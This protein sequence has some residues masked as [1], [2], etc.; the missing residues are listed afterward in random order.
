MTPKYTA[1]TK[2]KTVF[3]GT[4]TAVALLLSAAPV[5]TVVAA[6]TLTLS[7]WLPPTHPF[8][9]NALKPWADQV[10]EATNGN[11]RIRIL[12]KPLGSPLIH[13]DLA[14]DGIADISYGLQSYTKGTRFEVSNVAQFPFLGESAE[15]VSAAYWQVAEETP[16]IFAEH[17]GTHVLSLFTHGPG[18]IQ[19]RTENKIEK[20][21]DLE[22]LKV[23]VPGGVANDLIA[24]L[25]AEQM[26]VSPSE[27]YET[28]SRGVIDA[29]TM[30][31]ETMV[32]YKFIDAVD[33][34]TQIPGGLY[35]TT[36]FMSMN[37]GRWDSLSEDD[38]K[39]IMSVSGEAFARLQG[40]AWDVADAA[41]WEAIKEADIPVTVADDAF[42]AEINAA[43][44]PIEAEWLEK[45]AKKGVDGEALLAS[46]RAKAQQK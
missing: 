13:F 11:V 40:Q 7:S 31:A 26:L 39:A 25:G 17:E 10:R 16:E 5:T 2:L 19:N 41:A 37:Q 45:A 18:I 6:E 43:L 42:I 3:K 14:K 32:S 46:L 23:R 34:I 24:A 35:N 28:M 1:S 15:A 9:V 12:A 38:Q 8:V 22:G 30:P 44:E 27:I 36:W 4:L 33:N 29:L 21:A 20:A